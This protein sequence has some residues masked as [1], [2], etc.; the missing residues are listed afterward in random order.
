MGTLLLVKKADGGYAIPYHGDNAPGATRIDFLPGLW[1]G[2]GSGADARCVRGM[3]GLV[4][5][6]RQASPLRRTERAGALE[7]LKHYICRQ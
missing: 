6:R 7:E 1:V 3:V 4:G 2:I 5:A